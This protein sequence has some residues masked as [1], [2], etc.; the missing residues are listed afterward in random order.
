[1]SRPHGLSKSRYTSGLQCHKQLWWRT[2]E[3]QAPELVPEP[4]L[5]AVYDNGTHVG[6]VAR[7]YFP[8]GVLIDRPFAEFDARLADTQREIA[9]GAGVL[10]EAS[11]VA[12]GVFVAVDVLIRE[13][14]GWRVVEVKSS[15]QLKPPYIPDAAIQVHVLRRAGLTVMGADIMVLNRACTHP[16]L[17]NLF[18]RLDVSDQVESMLEQVP[19]EVAR[20]LAMLAGELPEVPVGPHC[21]QP[22]P[23]P[24]TARCWPEVPPHHVSTLYNSWRAVP[25][26]L[27]Q[28]YVTIADLPA[29]IKLNAQAGRQRRAVQSGR[30]IVEGPLAKALERFAGPLAF[31]DFETV[32]PAIPVWPG[33]HPYDAVPVQFSCHRERADGALEHLEWLTEGPGDP[34]HELA[35]RVIDACRGARTVV[36][37]N[38]SFEKGCLERLAVSSPA[39]APG[40]LDVVARLADP[41]PVVREHVYHPAFGGSFSLKAVLP[42]LVPGLS[43]DGLPIAEGVAASAALEQLLFAGDALPASE[44]ARLRTALLA[45]CERDT[46]ALVRLLDRLRSLAGR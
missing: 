40:L 42:A 2:H 39:L 5:Q 25:E 41:L 20:Q 36:A 13:G 19:G 4:A 15:T 32:Q 10:Y 27:E 18:Q 29:D 26:L 7:T 34:R 1:M 33:C 35:T 22:Y 28:G 11:F 8:G 14:R 12:D 17:S 24:F 31:L 37:Y 3:P 6:Q 30:L 23:C 45:Y 38:M 44:R 46:L 16:D 9:A 43:Y 21:R